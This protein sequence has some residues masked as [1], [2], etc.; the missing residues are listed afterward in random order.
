[1]ATIKKYFNFYDQK[2]QKD[3]MR[4][5]EKAGKCF[6]ITKLKNAC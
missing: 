4:G 3:R 5:N 2:E 6:R 1:M